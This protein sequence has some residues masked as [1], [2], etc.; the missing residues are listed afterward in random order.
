MQI[1][2]IVDKDLNQNDQ[3]NE[4]VNE[5]NNGI[6]QDE[7]IEIANDDDNQSKNNLNQNIKQ[8]DIS[9]KDYNEKES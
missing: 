2:E 1:I 6:D 8:I 7:L 5:F 4:I 9:K 3:N